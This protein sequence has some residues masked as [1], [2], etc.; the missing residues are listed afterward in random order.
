M[1]FKINLF[2]LEA[3]IKL[4]YLGGEASRFI[5]FSFGTTIS[6]LNFNLRLE[7]GVI[8][9]KGEELALLHVLSLS[10]MCNS[11]ILVD[12]KNRA[13]TIWCMCDLPKTRRWHL[14]ILWQSQKRNEIRIITRPDFRYIRMWWRKL[15]L[16]PLLPVIEKKG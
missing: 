2:W 14:D 15:S 6:R 11:F 4:F 10:P 1:L 9:R 12:R 16:Y 3:S 8:P 5:L 13:W 7:G